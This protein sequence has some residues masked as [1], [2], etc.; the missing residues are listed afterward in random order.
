MPQALY[1]QLC[2][3]S[4][5]AEGEEETERSNSMPLRDLGDKV[6]SDDKR[7]QARSVGETGTWI[8]AAKGTNAT[9]ATSLILQ[10][11]QPRELHYNRHAT[12]T[13][14][15]REEDL[16]AEIHKTLLPKQNH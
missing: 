15:E 8:S 4:K 3:T 1:P 14:S 16:Q 10:N 7:S 13:G 6:W 11:L 2:I 12:D 9:S 5:L